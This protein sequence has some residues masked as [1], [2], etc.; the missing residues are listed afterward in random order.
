[1]MS[2][3][4][5][6]NNNHIQIALLKSDM[7]SDHEI[8]IVTTII[9]K[10]KKENKTIDYHI[11]ELSEFQLTN[12]SFDLVLCFHDDDVLNVVR[13]IKPPLPL[14]VIELPGDSSFFSQVAL[15]NLDLAITKFLQ[16]EYILD[17]R[18]LLNLKLKDKEYLA[19]NDV[20]IT[21]SAI[22]TRIR[23]DIR[24]NGKSLYAEGNDSAN[25]ILLS[26]PTG[27]TA[28]SFNLGGA[29]IHPGTDVLQLLSIASRNITTHH[30]IIPFNSIIELDITEF[31]P[32]LV[33]NIDNYQF[34][35]TEHTFVFTK[36]LSGAIFITFKDQDDKIHTQSKLKNKLSYED[37]R[38]LTSTAKFL[39]FILKDSDKPLTINELIAKT[40]IQNQK[41]IRTA[42]NLLINKGFIKRREN[43]VDMR[44]YLYY[45][46][47][48]EEL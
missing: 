33:I 38:S 25:A 21:S 24:I 2:K 8:T 34:K 5:H 37:T 10:I 30:Q 26:T 46:V 15:K 4:S 35:T 41:T 42:L 20:H 6:I 45:Y 9:K 39:L 14:F 3:G 29:I 23:Y 43:Y 12:I 40:H 19:L 13:T 31:N 48:T 22:N 7:I 27:S 17:T 47:K 11:L 36:A 1:M 16:N 32:P 28:M 44:Q 18:N